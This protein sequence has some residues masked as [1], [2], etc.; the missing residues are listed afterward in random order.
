VVN[1]FSALGYTYGFVQTAKL[2]LGL[3]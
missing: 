3:P 2:T 1:I